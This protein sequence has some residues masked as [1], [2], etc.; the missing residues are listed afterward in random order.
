MC[1][2]LF[3]FALLLGFDPPAIED[4]LIKNLVWNRYITTN[5]TILSIDN[6]QGYWMKN[7]LEDIKSI[8]DMEQGKYFENIYG[9]GKSAIA[10]VDIIKQYF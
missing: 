5:F 6:D 2:L 10:I 8:I 1:N 4:P 3:V 7:N 9:D